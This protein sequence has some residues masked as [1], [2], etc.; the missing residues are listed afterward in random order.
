MARYFKVTIPNSTLPGPFDIKY[1]VIGSETLYTAELYPSLLPALN[2]NLSLFT[3]GNF[4]AVKTASE[5]SELIVSCTL[6]D[7]GIQKFIPPSV[8]PTATPTGTPTNTPSNTPTNTITSTPTNTATQ[9]PKPQ[10]PKTPPPIKL[11]GN[12]IK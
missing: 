3:G 4:V 11:Y 1:K 9:T 6:T 5:I 12:I 7:C 10:N 2:L 8:T